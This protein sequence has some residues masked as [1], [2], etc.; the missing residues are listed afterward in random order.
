MKKDALSEE[1]LM[2]VKASITDSFRDFIG[3]AD[4]EGRLIYLNDAAY[5]MM[6][7]G[8]D[9]RPEFSTIA[10]VHACDFEKFALEV[11]QPAVFAKGFWSG[12]SYLR[13]KDGRALNVAQTVFPVHGEDGT[14]YGTAAVM[15]DISE[16]TKMTEL[17]R[18]QD[19]L[20][21]KLLN[22]AKVGVVLINMET[23][24]IKMVNRSLEELLQMTEEEIVGRNCYDIL[25][26]RDPSI[27]PHENERDK[28]T[29]VAERFLQRKDGTSLPI[30]KTGTWI[31]IDGQEYLVD[32]MVDISIQKELENHLL[33]AKINAEAANRSKSEFLSRMSHEMR[34]PLNAIIGMAQV[35]NRPGAVEKMTEA[36]H[37]IEVSSTH[38]LGLIND[39]LD[40]SKI[41]EGKLE[42]SIE[43]FSLADAVKKICSLIEPK[44]R[45]KEIT[46]NVFIDS[47][48]PGKLL[49]DSMRLSQVLL[50]F[51]SN[52]VKFT[53]EKGWVNLRVGAVEVK[54]EKARLVFSVEDSG[55]G[56]T[57]EQVEK[58]FQPFVQAD[59][60]ISSQFGGTGLGLVISKRIINLMGSDIKVSSRYGE[61][62]VFSFALDFTVGADTQEEPEETAM[63][64]I[65][66]IFS[67]KKALIVDDVELNRMVAAALL[68][69]TG[70]DL[71]EAGD[72]REAVQ[73]VALC[74][75]DI[76]LMDVQMPVMDG[77]EAT[78]QIRALGPEC[79][80]IP[81][82]AMSANVFKE[83]VERC[84]A[85]GMNGHIGK[86]IDMQD[87]I[88]TMLAVLADKNAAAKTALPKGAGGVY[89]RLV[90]AMKNGEYNQAKELASQMREVAQRAKMPAVASYADNVL[91][92]LNRRS[93][94]Y[95]VMYMS[96]LVKT[97]EK[98]SND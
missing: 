23:K 6:G 53:P 94:E 70:L 64:D 60:S 97:Y 47:A 65:E 57:D 12:M 81:I 5:E 18:K 79:R 46:F 63:L 48:V 38:L 10:D 15:K 40:L 44:A 56:M 8:R 2:R 58:I 80:E 39:I 1:Y 3:I 98:M 43:H 32:T 52:A 84:L 68:E 30:I 36:V 51:L 31:N 62:T 21:R 42:L 50:N 89:E 41:E 72:G 33:E 96:D 76:V 16:I 20:F 87:M 19:E 22:A 71:D 67:G 7:Y 93:Y 75:Y 4:A 73:K 25:C 49:G 13:H 86:P 24:S 27:C 11:V 17:V 83:D 85:A 90:S 88:N 59:G 78:R 61:G 9:E 66:G 92:C 26:H 28:D 95:A 29:I 34:T 35:A 91:E 69:D 82:V 45:E 37:T 54:E 77:F 14:M 74:Q 55:I